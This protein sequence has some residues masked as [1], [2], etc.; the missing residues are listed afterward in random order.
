MISENAA[1][2]IPFFASIRDSQLLTRRYTEDITTNYF[3]LLKSE[4]NRN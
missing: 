3:K 2:V 1:K 4:S